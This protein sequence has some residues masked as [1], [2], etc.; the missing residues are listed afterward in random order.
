LIFV[1]NKKNELKL[2]KIE[3]DNLLPIRFISRCLDVQ[4]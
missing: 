4:R 2:I 1:I 3:C